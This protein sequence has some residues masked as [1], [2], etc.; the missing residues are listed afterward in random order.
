M[1]RASR[2][3]PTP[4]SPCNRT[5]TFVGQMRITL[6]RNC[7]MA[8]ELPNITESGGKSPYL[9]LPGSSGESLIACI[10]EQ[11]GF[12]SKVAPFWLRSCATFQLG[13]QEHGH[14]PAK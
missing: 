11:V 5:D 12:Q 8:S 1:K 13:G 9:S 10:S 4:G 6:R 7:C 3:L 2:S 14:I